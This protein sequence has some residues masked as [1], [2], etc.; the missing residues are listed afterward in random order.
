MLM[1]PR[2]YAAITALPSGDESAI[3]LLKSARHVRTI[4]LTPFMVLAWAF[5]VFLFLAYFAPDWEAPSERLRSVPAWFWVK[6]ALA[7]S[8]TAYHGLL[9]AEGRHLAAGERRRS[10]QFWRV[11]S[12]VPFFVAAA[13]VLLA[14]SEP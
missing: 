14:T 11:L 13:I 5:G 4:V 2:L 1:L 6:L 9:N 3:E 7:F 10:E 8:L 12:I